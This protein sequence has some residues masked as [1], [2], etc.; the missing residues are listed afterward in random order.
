LGAREQAGVRVERL[1]VREFRSYERASFEL[2]DGITV[3][4]GPNGA[5]KTNLL[6][7]LYVGCTGRPVRTR[8][9]RE[10]VR[11]GADGARVTIHTAGGAAAHVVNVVVRRSERKVIRVDGR[12]V[13]RIDAG[14]TRPF[15][16]VFIPDRL[17]L[18][19][20]PP[21]LR[22]AH[23]DELAG[24][25]WPARGND[26]REYA[27]A[28]AQRNALLA[29]IRSSRLSRESLPAWDRELAAHGVRL[30][31]TRELV[32]AAL[33]EPFVER[34]RQLGL[35]GD[36]S[37]HYRP[38]AR[39]D[40]PDSFLAA[41]QERLAS[42]L[43][44][45]FCTYGP[46]RDELILRVDGH[47]VRSYSSQ[48]EQRLAMLALLFAERDLL[49]RERGSLPLMLLD[50]VF[51]ELDPGRR[52]RLVAELSLRGQSVIT[53]TDRRQLSSADAATL[54]TLE[55]PGDVAREH[56]ASGDAASELHALPA[57]R[58]LPA[59]AA[60]CGSAA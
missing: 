46:H 8:S 44:R 42:D 27:R 7:A 24:A 51:S 50:D 10:L 11:F 30:R 12:Q 16:C 54:R 32:T 33:A 29:S 45:G 55:I 35:E 20:G 3:L 39:E 43:E 47:A 18:L 19:K 36:P 28:L 25:L 21:A 53:T 38:G 5:G 37:V 49:E 6:E 17:A 14:E 58:A 31:A 9:E 40:D 2:G 52:T 13:E 56:G 1:E 15:V 23:L 34:A 26:R 57:G 22:R 60:L 59:A 4:V 48:G 41:L